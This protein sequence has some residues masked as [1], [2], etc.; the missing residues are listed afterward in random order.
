MRP[1][2]HPADHEGR[3]AGI[4]M[5]N[6]ADRAKA[7]AMPEW[8]WRGAG[9]KAGERPAL[10]RLFE[11]PAR[12]RAGAPAIADGSVALSFEQLERGARA[13]AHRLTAA[14]VRSGDCVLVLTEKRAVMAVVAAG[15]WKAGGI[16]V[17]VDGEAPVARL[18]DIATQTR[19]AAIVGSR[20]AVDAHGAALG[21][22]A[23]AC[24][25]FEQV[26]E[27]IEAWP[28]DGRSD[29]PSVA[30]HV[31][32]YVIFTSGS[33]GTPKGV[34]ISHRSLLDY[35]Y[36][37]NQV[38][39]YTP[40]SR[41]FSLAPFHFDVSIED[42]LLPLSLGAY[43]Y[44]FRGLPLGPMLR[45]ALQRERITHL[46]AVSTLLGL[47][48]DDGREISE[49]AL[50][51]LRMLMTGAEVCDP[52][53]IDLWVQRFPQARVI[54]AYGPTEA[55]I[56]CLTHTIDRA[57]P[58]PAASYPIGRPLPGVDILLLD[59]DGRTIDAPDRTGELLIGGSQVMVGYL[60]RPEE[61]AQACPVIAGRRYYRSGDR[62]YYDAQGR[63]VYLERMDDMVKIGGQR[64]HLGEIRQRALGLPGVLRAAV[65]EMRVD[66]LTAIALAVVLQ[67]ADADDATCAAEARRIRDALARH[68]PSYMLPRVLALTGEARVTSSGKTDERAL[69]DRL[70]V[71]VPRGKGNY[72]IA[73]D[74]GVVAMSEGVL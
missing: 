33:T 20:R 68:L 26:I 30:E 62:C 41:V 55:T 29:V 74:L 19:P 11:W 57:E 31:P 37:H 28:D 15:I 65:G 39:R 3:R 52:K 14:G 35:F 32:A 61:T 7:D 73:P 44:Q 40:E 69:L 51:D 67:G 2:R 17:P 56:V 34:V 70:R 72:Y 49:A 18:I 23:H 27:D 71:A 66:G 43:V 42:T 48:T 25:A 12:H 53:L 24:I 21:A 64:V 13:L 58:M 46:I 4:A 59:D 10:A 1:L 22:A 8:A 5:G 63:V 38:L 54:N 50:P 45:K 9:L 47:I 36:N 6:A 16:Y 60:N